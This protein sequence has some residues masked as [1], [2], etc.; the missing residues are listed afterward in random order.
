MSNNLFE[1]ARQR[2]VPDEMFRVYV[3]SG[4]IDERFL[5]RKHK[6]RK[7]NPDL[8]ARF[9][10]TFPGGIDPNMEGYKSASEDFLQTLAFIAAFLTFAFVGLQAATNGEFAK[11]VVSQTHHNAGK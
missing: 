2:G 6:Y 8:A 3:S 10:A 11:K 9:D 7:E 5:K 4:K 1:E